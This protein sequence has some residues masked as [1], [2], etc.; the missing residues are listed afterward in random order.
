MDQS[1]YLS[2]AEMM[3]TT[4][5]EGVGG[6]NRMPTY[7]A[8]LALLRFGGVSQSGL[9]AAAKTAGIGI[10]LLVLAVAYFLFR[11]TGHWLD[12]IA[13]TLVA[14]YTALVF[15]APYA[16]ADVLFYGLSF[17]SFV[18]CL[19]LVRKPRTSIGIAA[20]IVTGVAFL[21]K[22][23]V[24]PL[25]VLTVVCIAAPTLVIRRSSV[26]AAANV[27]AVTRVATTIGLVLAFLATVFPYL[28]TSKDRFGHYFYNVNTTFYVW[29]DSWDE[30]ERGTKAHGD[31][32]GW[33]TMPP[34]QVPSLGKYLREHSVEE[35]ASRLIQGTKTIVGTALRSY[36]YAF[37]VLLY[38]SFLSLLHGRARIG[39]MIRAEP[40]IA[41]FLCTFFMGYAVSYAWYVP[42]ANGNRFTLSLLLPFLFLTVNGL[43]IAR[44]DRLAV[45]V[46]GWPITASSCQAVALAC[47]VAFLVFI[48][49]ARI[50][51]QYGG[52]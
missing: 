3:Y 30:V 45:S 21:T 16:Q 46:G 23:A 42:I 28:Q 52:D 2:Y 10:A 34:D 11:R 49:P 14:A 36:G 31:R 7:P 6:R 18:L 17:V 22:A 43:R 40:M 9:F 47:L 35:I 19:S 27:R 12:A 4:A 50:A 48:F 25:L 32:I 38:A 41:L 8:L 13:A 5:F 39:S 26:R 24:V 15:K 37:F 29:Y 44:Q 20:G 33:P 1:A 51:M